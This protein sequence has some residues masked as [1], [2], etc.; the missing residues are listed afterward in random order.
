MVQR[1]MQN[2]KQGLSKG[3]YA[4]KFCTAQ[5]E[6]AYTALRIAHCAMSTDLLQVTDTSAVSQLPCQSLILY[7]P[8]LLKPAKPNTAAT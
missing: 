6:A 3:P 5:E 1:M 4:V 8:Q 2:K 7:N